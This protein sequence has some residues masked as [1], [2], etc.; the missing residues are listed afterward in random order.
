[1]TSDADRLEQLG[2]A[3]ELRRRGE[4]ARRSDGAMAR[5]C[6]EE[7][8]RLFREVGEPLTL[9]HTVRHL[10]DVY[11]EEGLSGLVEPCYH[12]A[13]SIYRNHQTSPSL[14]LANAIRSLAVL[15]WEQARVLWEEARDL[16][17]ALGIE[18]GINEGTDRLKALSAD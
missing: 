14:D 9:A 12:E 15:R 1:M 11:H 6:H 17:S 2:R 8:V 13:L 10:G 3:R 4:A 7:A 18:A 16:Y 5:K